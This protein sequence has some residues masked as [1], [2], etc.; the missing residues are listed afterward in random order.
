MSTWL[1]WCDRLLSDDRSSSNAPGSRWN[2]DS[3]CFVAALTCSRAHFRSL[4]RSDAQTVEPRES[5]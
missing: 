3:P 5:K 1:S 2:A 4:P